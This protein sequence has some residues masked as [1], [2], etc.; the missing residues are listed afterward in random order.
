MERET[1]I[2]KIGENEVKV[3]TYLTGREMRDIQS[4]MLS[5][6]EMKQK[7]D[8]V[9]MSGFNGAM[10]QSQEDQQIIAVVKEVNGSTEDILGKVLDMRSEDYFAVVEY[11]KSIAEKKEV[12]SK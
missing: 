6:L 9:E 3:V 12:A 2:L 4:S 11:V 1:K 10:V 7:G 5:K 8:E